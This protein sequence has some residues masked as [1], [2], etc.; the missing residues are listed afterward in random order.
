MSDKDLKDFVYSIT[1][2][3]SSP[4]R[5]IKE[6]SKRLLAD[7]DGELTPKQKL[8]SEL[9]T[10]SIVKSEILMQN[11]SEYALITQKKNSAKSYYVGSDIIEPLIIQLKKYSDIY[12]DVEFEIDGPDLIAHVDIQYLNA[13]LSYLIQNAVIYKKEEENPII[14]IEYYEKEKE[15]LFCIKDNGIGISED[16]FDLIFRLSKVL[17]PQKYKNSKGAGLSMAKKIIEEVFQGRIWLE[18]SPEGSNFYFTVK[19]IT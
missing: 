1:H 19:N 10:D 6:F 14:K 16:N 3:L 2:D 9:V 5:I 18:S 17:D 12:K 13:V 15:V 7:L 4:L 8:Y 11:I